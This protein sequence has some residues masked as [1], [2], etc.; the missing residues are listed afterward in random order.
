MLLHNGVAVDLDS[1][2]VTYQGKF[3]D[4]TPTEYRL[5]VLF[6]EYPNH[7]FDYDFISKKLWAEEKTPTES[8]IRSHIKRLRQALK[9]VDESADIIDNIHGIG[10]RLKLDDNKKIMSEHQNITKIIPNFSILQQILELKNIDYLVIDNK[11]NIHYYSSKL[12]QYS[13]APEYLEV[14]NDARNAFPE[15]AGLEEV[16]EKLR[17]Q[18]IKSFQMQGISRVAGVDNCQYLNCYIIGDNCASMK[19]K[20]EAEQLQ[21][22]FIFFEDASEMMLYKQQVV[23]R[24]LEDCLL[25]VT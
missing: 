14:G 21:L 8:C 6:L 4:L 18:E 1:C 9:K 2:T 13:E 20:A 5:L 16:F 11:F 12:S 17:R 24:E 3:V 23:Q 7:V 22:L 15:L 19:M 10:Y 25:S